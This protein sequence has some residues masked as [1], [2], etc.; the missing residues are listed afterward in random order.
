MTDELLSLFSLSL[1]LSSLILCCNI[2]ATIQSMVLTVSRDLMLFDNEVVR[3]W[4][5]VDKDGFFL[6]PLA[7]TCYC[8]M[9]SL[10]RFLFL[11]FSFFPSQGV[12]LSTKRS[13]LPF[14][15]LW[16]RMK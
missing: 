12:S 8:L 1:S 4:L 14:L 3:N 11:F 16:F 9:C 13:L 6:S 15:L 7:L 10:L 5:L 2:I